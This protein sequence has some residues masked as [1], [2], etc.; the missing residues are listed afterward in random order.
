MFSQRQATRKCSLSGSIGLYL[1]LSGPLVSMALSGSLWLSS[2]YGSLWIYRT[3]SLF[4]PLC[5]CLPSLMAQLLVVCSIVLRSFCQTRPV[6]LFRHKW[7]ERP[8]KT[9]TLLLNFLNITSASTLFLW[10][11][12]T[13]LEVIRHCEEVI[14]P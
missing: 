5:L 9:P 2:L 12:L 10:L 8:R 4:G 1:A 11:Y 13:L 3:L 6:N 14:C 7:A